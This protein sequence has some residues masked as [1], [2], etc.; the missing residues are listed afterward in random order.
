[1]APTRS[2]RLKVVKGTGDGVEGVDFGDPLFL[3]VDMQD[4]C[5]L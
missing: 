2:V 3:K 4:E 1:M 5:K